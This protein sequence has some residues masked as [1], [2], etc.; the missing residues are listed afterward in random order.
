MKGRAGARVAGG[1]VEGKGSCQDG[2]A[3]AHTYLV[4][5]VYAEERKV[6]AGAIYE[7]R[8][9]EPSPLSLLCSGEE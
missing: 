6:R 1:R 5:C 8:K 3:R 7:K 2:M 4:E 9:C